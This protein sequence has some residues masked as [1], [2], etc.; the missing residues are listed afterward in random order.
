MMARWAAALSGVI[1]AMGHPTRS[2]RA[3]AMLRIAMGPITLLHLRPFLE[4]LADGVTYQDRFHLP[5]WDWYPAAGDPVYGVLLVSAAVAAALMCLGTWTRV[6]TAYL[7][8]FV[9]YN[10]YLSKTHFHHNRAFLIIIL[11]GLALLP[12]GRVLSV[13]AWIRRRRG[14]G[15]LPLR[16][17]CGPSGCCGSRS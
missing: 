12:A 14:L 15:H 9:A 6:S 17:R 11:V 8:C 2:V 5:F 16:S 7:A 1:D 13:D 10:V 4:N 3:I